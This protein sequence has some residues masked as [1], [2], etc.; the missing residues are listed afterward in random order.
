MIC[1][2]L[3]VEVA[4]VL[5]DKQEQLKT[6]SSSAG[7]KTKRRK[8]RSVYDEV[9]VEIEPSLPA[10]RVSAYRKQASLPAS[11]IS[12]DGRQATFSSPQDGCHIK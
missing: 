12:D 4:I 1:A 5:H 2:L 7:K 3:L 9:S 8:A 6:F 10:K 11:G